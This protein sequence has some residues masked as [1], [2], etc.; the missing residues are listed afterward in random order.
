[1]SVKIH[2]YL[3]LMLAYVY[4]IGS[5]RYF[6]YYY[7]FVIMHELAHIVVALV[8]KIDIQEIILLPIGVNAKYSDNIPYIKELIISL[9]GPLASF[10]F[11][12][13]FKNEIYSYMNICIGIFNLIPVYPFD[14]GKIIRNFLRIL[15]KENIAKKISNNIAKMFVSILT[16][17]ALT[18]VAFFRNYYAI[19]ITLYIFTVAIDE[20]KKEKFYGL[21][22]YLQKE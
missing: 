6:V 22:N 17:I 2:I 5:F 12:S 15:L 18:L 14:G 10:L 11:A 9:A 19:I 1:M 8:L 20:M 13:I 3:L 21:I 16:I 7:L 4:A